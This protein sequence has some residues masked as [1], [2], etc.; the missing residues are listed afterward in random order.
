MT[1]KLNERQKKFIDALFGEARG[2]YRKAMDIAGYARN[3]KPHNILSKEAIQ[4]EITLRVQDHI[5]FN[6][7]SAIF[8]L[9]D[10]LDDPTMPGSREKIKVAQ[11]ILDRIGLGKMERKTVEHV[12]PQPIVILPPKDTDTE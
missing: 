6:G 5:A 9:E 10:V 12:G 7:P 3:T 1:K 11:D 2:H 4:E 8:S